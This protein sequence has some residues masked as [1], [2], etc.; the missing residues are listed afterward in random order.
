MSFS[1]RLDRWFG[2][3]PAV[4]EK[5]VLPHLSSLLPHGN[6]DFDSGLFSLSTKER[7]E[8]VGFCLEVRP[9][10]GA[11]DGIAALIDD[12]ISSLPEQACMQVSLYADP[13]IERIL[14]D[15][16]EL[17]GRGPSAIHAEL[18][19]RRCA[20][21]RHAPVFREIPGYLLRDFRLF[22]SV[23]LDGPLTDRGAKERISR[24]RDAVKGSLRSA[25]FPFADLGACDLAA[26]LGALLSPL[27]PPC[28]D[29]AKVDVG[30]VRDMVAIGDVVYHVEE[31]CITAHHAAADM[32]IAVMSVGAYPPEVQLHEMG[33]VIGDFSHESLSY[34]SPFLVTMSL[35]MC[36]YE[37][38]RQVADLRTARAVQNSSSPMARLMPG[39]YERQRDDWAL[40]GNVL[41]RGGMMVHLAHHV[42]LFAQP[43]RV[44][45]A[46]ESAK[47]VWRARGFGLAGCRFMQVQGL[48]ASLPLGLT[49]GLAADLRTAG[50]MRRLTHHNAARTA[51]LI[52]EW[53]GTRTP[54][55]LLF[56]RRGQV[57]P[58]DFFDNDAGNYNVVVAGASGTG[59]SMLL[60]EVAASYLATGAQIWIIDVGRSYEK[61]CRLLGG[62]FVEFGDGCPT[63][64]LNPFASVERLD[65]D[66]ELLEPLFALMMS[67][68]HPLS[69]FQRSKL[70]A[71]VKRAYGARGRSATPGDLRDALLD[72]EDRADSRVRDMAVMLQPYTPDGVY[73]PMFGG[74]GSSH[75]SGRLTVIELEDLKSKRDLQA[76][77]L[78]MLMYR[79]SQ[80]MYHDRQRRKLVIIDEAWDLM[81]SPAS[82]DFIEHGYRR[83]R[84]YNGAFLSAAQSI[85]D[86][87]ANPSALAA[88][89][90]SDWSMLLRQKAERIAQ[91]AEENRLVLG[92]GERDML[93]SLHTR[94]GL[95]SEILIRSEMG[96]GV[97]RLIVDPFA[98]LLYSSRPQDYQAVQSLVSEGVPLAQAI[99]RIVGS[100]R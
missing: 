47:A 56:G 82:A 7:R 6:F 51:P 59:K 71:A 33:G 93:L 32:S 91:L 84:K 34:E 38:S 62:E 65:A 55:M 36:D 9:Q 8:C 60:N 17:R 3:E 69:E 19:R 22:I 88:L 21:F 50:W 68:T 5:P 64:S 15:Y 79:I 44:T 26:L 24:V 95:F 57:M 72:D 28:P 18:A 54:V 41:K 87:H 4:P 42:V 46:C 49:P 45:A 85:G 16:A 92:D 20:E 27:R 2:F 99:E 74:Q 98:R 73:G 29:S 1:A 52:A 77:V 61:T 63:P 35:R 75:F 11:D 37:Q 80:E 90:N 10:T 58:I 43:G 76:I 12:L 83:A 14:S 31:D 97:G 23:T 94:Q 67:P 53:K 39:H 30:V 89:E 70:Q 66:M 13:D 96:S 81:R 40:V 48:L 25:Y 100:R 78:F 86:F